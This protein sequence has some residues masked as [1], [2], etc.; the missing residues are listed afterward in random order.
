[1]PIHD[2]T[3]VTAGTFHAFHNAWIAELQGAMNSGVLPPNYYALAEQVAGEVVPDV[4][5]LQ[6]IRPNSSRDVNSLDNEVAIGDADTAI[7][8]ATLPPKVSISDTIT[9]AM[10]LAARQSQLVIRHTTGDRVVAIAEVVS[11]G[12][13]ERGGAFEA[14]IEKVLGALDRGI[15]FLILDLYPP[16][17]HDPRGIHAAIWEHLKGTFNPPKNKPLTLASYVSSGAVTCYVEPAAVGDVL[18]QMP[19]FLSRAT[20]VNVPLEETYISAFKKLPQKWRRVLEG[21][22]G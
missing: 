15:H 8:V 17:L 9:E 13:K 19:L 1:M 2:W 3:R 10:L 18:I 11:S 16:G 7:A 6:D 4:L 21:Q 22:T 12:N 14:F 20:Y 5:T